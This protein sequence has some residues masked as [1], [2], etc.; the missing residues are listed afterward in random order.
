MLRSDD[1]P[2]WDLTFPRPPSVRV[3]TRP[4]FSKWDKEL[5]DL[6]PRSADVVIC[7]VSTETCVLATALGAVDSG[8]RVVVVPTAC[9]GATAALHD[10]ALEVLRSF[11]PNVTLTDVEGALALTDAPA[12]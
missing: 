5:E 11:A 9:A 12:T 4:T 7:G 3:I 1:D 2:V 6:I 8:R 10:A